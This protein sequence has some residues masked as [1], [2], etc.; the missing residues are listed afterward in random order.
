MTTRA[1]VL[2]DSVNE[3]TGDRLTTFKLIYPR[4][5]HSEF[6]TVRLFS[7]NAASSRAIPPR[8]LIEEVSNNPAMPAQWGT[9]KAGMQAGPPLT[10][11]AAR[12]AEDW[13]RRGADFA[14]THAREGL[15]LG[16]HK[17]VVNRWLETPGH[18]TVLVTASEFANFFRLRAHPDADPTFIVLAFRMLRAYLGSNPQTLRPGEWHIPFGDR[19]P[20]RVRGGGEL[21]R[22]CEDCAGDGRWM[23]GRASRFHDCG[24]RELLLEERLKIAAARAARLSYLTFEGLLDLRKDFALHDDLMVKGHWSP[25]EHSARALVAGEAAHSNFRGFQQYRELVDTTT[26]VS[27][28]AE[29]L[30][31]ILA[32][33]PEWVKEAA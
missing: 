15:E 20:K 28:T 6:N 1:D 4:M 9:M 22:V 11:D 30:W 3:A 19:M 27:A 26:W 21:L 16:L 7:R 13:W 14:V 31:A 32:T 33:E 8:K 12:A 5:V 25:F 17:Q 24:C 18:I 10:G 23:D 29:E 2:L